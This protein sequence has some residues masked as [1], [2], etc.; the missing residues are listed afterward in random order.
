[1]E[2]MISHVKNVTAAYTLYAFGVLPITSLITGKLD[3]IPL[4]RR[5]NLKVDL[6]F[7]KALTQNVTM[8][9]MGK[10]PDML[11][12]YSARNVML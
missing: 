9:V 11:Q 8:V 3:H 5:G 12:I 1:M 6:T 7:Q 10:F 2:A 4:I